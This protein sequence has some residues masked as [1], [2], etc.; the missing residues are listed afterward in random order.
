MP[1][2]LSTNPLFNRPP[3]PK[4]SVAR[5]ETELARLPHLGRDRRHETAEVRRRFH[6]ARKAA[7]AAEAVGRL[8]RADEA[9]HM[10]ISG[11][12]ALWHVVPATLALA[13]CPI[14]ELSIAT[15]GFSR[16][17]ISG[18]CDLLDAGSVRCARLLASHYFK[19][20]SAE[21]YA[22]AAEELGKRA[23]RAAFV[24]LRS[25]AKL[26]LIGLADGLYGFHR[27]WML[28]LFAAAAAGKD[29]AGG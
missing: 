9:V 21:I 29:G 3:A 26:L 8:P 23:D 1:L 24:S 12:F 22:F 6:D 5:I 10:A 14:A 4:L 15:L 20:T 27:G 25:H 17:N 7:D 16:Q 19:G 11:R 18:L 28:E 13:G 2:A